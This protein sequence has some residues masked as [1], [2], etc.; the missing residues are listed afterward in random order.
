MG[1]LSDRQ[2]LEAYCGGDRGAF[3]ALF[4]RYAPRIHATAYRLTANWEDAE[5]ALQEVFL[6]LA[7]KAATIRRAEALAAWLY[8][9]TVS[10]A[11]D[12]L[13]RRRKTISLDESEFDSARIVAVESLRRET[14]RERGQ[15]R[16]ALLRQIE[17]MVP[18]LPERQAA[19]F[20]LRAFQGLSHRDIA[21]VLGM[22]EGSSKSHYSLACQKLRD[23]VAQA[24]EME[25]KAQR[26]R[27]AVEREL[28]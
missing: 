1:E 8:R 11:M 10:C 22:S 27:K 19:V 23:W 12:C 18:N 3:D 25:E 9:T 20:V 17:A 21:A 14:E 13:R 6:R 2:L 5:D 4:R 7:N 16:D 24:E 15:Y 28:V 26:R